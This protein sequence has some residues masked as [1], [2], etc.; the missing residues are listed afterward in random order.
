M[1]TKTGGGGGIPGLEDRLLAATATESL[2]RMWA[3]ASQ[4]AQERER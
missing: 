1:K 2:G 4:Q 3:Y